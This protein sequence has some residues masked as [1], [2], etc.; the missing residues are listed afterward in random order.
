MN[1]KIKRGDTVVVYS[2]DPRHRPEVTEVAGIGKKYITVKVST[3]HN[4]YDV[5]DLT[6]VDWSCWNLF[7]GTLEEYK[8]YVKQQEEAKELRRKLLD[9]ISLADYDELKAIHNFLYNAQ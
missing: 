7:H 5:G 4:R 2:S 9:R 3:D 1:K 8:E 6:C